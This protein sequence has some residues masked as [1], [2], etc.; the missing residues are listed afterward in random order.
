MTNICRICG[1]TESQAVADAK[2]LGLEQELESGVY[3]CCQIAEWTLE[4][5]FAW[6]EA[7]QEDG[8]S[9]D[10]MTKLNGLEATEALLVPV[11]VRRPQV[12]RVRNPDHRS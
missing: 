5:L 4:Q 7:T 10:N 11:R 3:T 8:K 9:A 1:S 2:A 12:A 6:S